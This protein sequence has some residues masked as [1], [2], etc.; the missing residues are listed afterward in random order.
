MLEPIKTIL[1]VPHDHH[2][3]Y[4]CRYCGKMSKVM[5]QSGMNPAGLRFLKE[6]YPD[7][8]HIQD[9][10]CIDKVV[11]KIEEEKYIAQERIAIAREDWKQGAGKK[12]GR[13]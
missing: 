5:D 13:R 10:D 6:L 4:P 1:D 11:D 12:G 3:P 7:G 9:C 8:F 2:L